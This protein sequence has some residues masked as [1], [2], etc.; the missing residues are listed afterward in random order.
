MVKT[1]RHKTRLIFSRAISAR[2]RGQVLAQTDYGCQKCGRTP[3]E[4]DSAT[5]R[6][7]RSLHVGYSKGR[8]LGGKDALSNVRAIC[9][10]CDQGF[11]RITSEERNGIWLLSQVQRAGQDEQRSVF[12][13][14]QK[15]FAALDRN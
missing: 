9:S 2:M 5:G 3:G 13:W 6:K 12:E 8:R 10:I 1:G 11:R 4:I 7:V 14:L 15:E